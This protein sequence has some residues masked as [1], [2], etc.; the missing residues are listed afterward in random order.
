MT[1]DMFTAV[2]SRPRV[3]IV[4]G[5]FAGLARDRPRCRGARA[6]SRGL[7]RDVTRSGIEAQDNVSAVVVGR[8]RD[9]SILA[10]ATHDGVLRLTDLTAGVPRWSTAASGQ[11]AQL[12]A[13]A[14]GDEPSLF[15][16][17][18]DGQLRR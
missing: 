6:R 10:T 17:H 12:L 2:T 5:G 4:G 13:F 1:T 18:P 15:S 7:R 8:S 9:R 16:W 3:V 14:S 11:P